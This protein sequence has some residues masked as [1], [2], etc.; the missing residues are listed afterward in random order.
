MGLFSLARR[1]GSSDF[2]ARRALRSRAFFGRDVLVIRAMDTLPRYRMGAASSWQAAAKRGS[3][4]YIGARLQR[5]TPQQQKMKDCAGKWQEEKAKT[6]RKG[7]TPYRKFMG[8]C[9]KEKG[10]RLNG[11]RQSRPLKTARV[12]TTVRPRPRGTHF[13]KYRGRRRE[14]GATSPSANVVPRRG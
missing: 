5:M 6:G 14:A 10:P 9:L 3:D 4:H 1:A 11:R 13:P 12:R 7:R 2:D 8:E